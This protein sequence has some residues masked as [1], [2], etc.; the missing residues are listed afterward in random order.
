M[1]DHLPG[2]RVRF[3]GHDG[4]IVDAL[5]HPV[6]IISSDNRIIKV[7]AAAEIFFETGASVMRRGKLADYLPF[8]S[9]VADLVEQ[10]RE[11]TTSV[12][13]YR[14]DVGTPRIGMGRIVDVHAAV[15]EFDPVTVMLLLQERTMADKID[16]QM[17]SRGAA[18]SVTGLAAM[19]AHEI[20]N[21]LSGIRGAA[22][23]LESSVETED[24]SLTRLIRDEA[25]RIVRLVDRME[26]FSDDRPINREPVNLHAVF[27]HVR[28]LAEQGFGGHVRFFENYDPSLPPV[29]GNR[30]QLIQV[31]LNLVKNACEAT[32]QSIDAEITMTSRF[33]PGMRLS[34]PG[35][36]SSVA[37]PLEFC[38]TDNGPGVSAD[39]VSDMFDPFITTKP[40]GSGL[41]L[42]LVAKIVKDHGGMIECDSVPRQTRFR[43]LLPAFAEEI[44]SQR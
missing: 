37:L 31:F 10:V 43:V 23:L 34:V 16:R 39:V 24:R 25:D 12:N 15:I 33:S 19:L 32:Q 44:E 17:T 38:V 18:R 13:E 7:N 20:K 22:Q 29:H 5:P 4:L 1:A 26:V 40:N 21:P 6:L 8:G 42:A 27:D 35:S 36:K 3:T 30:D 9:P 2:A 28:Q 14:I 11:H 41:G